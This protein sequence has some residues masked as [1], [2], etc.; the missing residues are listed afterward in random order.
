MSTQLGNVLLLAVNCSKKMNWE[1]KG[2]GHKLI[3]KC[4]SMFGAA[5]VEDCE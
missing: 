4:I 2:K 5:V 1:I 3:E